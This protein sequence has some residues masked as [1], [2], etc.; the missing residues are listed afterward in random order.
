[1]DHREDRLQAIRAAYPLQCQ[2]LAQVFDDVTNSYKLFW[3]LALL[4]R[5]P[6]LADTPVIVAELVTEMHV[7]AWHPVTLYRLSLG[8]QDKLQANVR[9]AREESSL[10]LST[11]LENVRQDPVVVRVAADGRDLARYVPFRFLSPWFQDRL[12]SLKDVQKNAAIRQAAHEQRSKPTASPYF[13]QNDPAL[14]MALILDPGWH[15]FL[16]ENRCIL[17]G[18]ARHHL[19]SFLQARNPGVPGIVDKLDPPMVRALAPARKFWSQ[20]IT[21]LREQ[22]EEVSDLYSG[23]PLD[24]DFSIDHFLPWSF[25]AHDLGWNLCPANK[26]TNSAKGDKVPSLDRYLDRFVALHHRVLRISRP[27]ERLLQD[28][29]NAFR[30]DVSIIQSMPAEEFLQRYRA[31]MVPQVQTAKNMGFATN[32]TSGLP[33]GTSDG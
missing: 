12:R 13:L 17:E 33:P 22:G 23:R 30:L 6:A 11:S 20:S 3:F 7:L 9:K 27:T 24:P 32:W 31:L 18:F 29:C 8:Q 16:L 21:Q 19:V 15:S 2:T 25:V 26:A 4:N 28:Y 5:L 1:M 14:G 10:L